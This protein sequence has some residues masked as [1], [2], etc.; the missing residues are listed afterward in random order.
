MVATIAKTIAIIAIIIAIIAI[1]LVTQVVQLVTNCPQIGTKKIP[2]AR[3][4][5]S[6][7]SN[8]SQHK[9]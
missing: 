2:R 7:Q 3:R 5:I 4:M 1:I 8:A 6:N 9:N